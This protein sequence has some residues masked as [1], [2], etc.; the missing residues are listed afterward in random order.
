MEGVRVKMNEINVVVAEDNPEAADVLKN[1]LEGAGY[2][3]WICREP[4]EALAL[5]RTAPVSVLITEL[6]SAKMNGV[7]VVK[8]AHKISPEI[9][10]IVITYYS[11]INS[12][13]EAMEAGAYGYIT[14]PLNTSEIRIVISRAVERF[15][16][17][18][19]STEKDYY[20]D[21][22]V[23]DGLTGLYNRRYLK[24]LISREVVRMKRVPAAFS[25][26]MIDI[27]NFKNYNDTH[28]HPAGDGLLKKAA[29]IFK[30]SLREVDIV[31]RYG[32]EEFVVLLPQTDKKSAQFAAERL[33][34]QINVFLPTTISLGIATY[35][36]DTQD[37]NELTEKADAAL[38]KA[39][40]SGKNKWCAA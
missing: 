22:A 36:D 7:E 2:R 35:P 32:G 34:V 25:I 30:N 15:Y 21:M 14:K 16:L 17:L 29:E 4:K 11:F 9:N 24:E 12:A 1:T 38:Y 37:I 13:I 8:N 33:R 19:N 28:G 5:L 20:A 6:R 26:L 39:K 3:V 40:Q 18:N 23:R 27:D 10:V 31:C